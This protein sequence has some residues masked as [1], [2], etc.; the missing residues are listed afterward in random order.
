MKRYIPILSLLVIVLTLGVGCSTPNRER[1]S[2]NDGWL[3]MLGENAEAAE[4][5]Y[6]DS[7]WRQLNLPHDWS[8]ELPFAEDAPAGPGGGA[9]PGGL[10]WYRKHFTVGEEIK[11]KQVYIDFDG[12]YMNSEVFINGHSLGV[13]PFGYI[14]FRYDLTPYLKPGEDNVIAV[15]VD[16]SKQQ[17]G[18]AACRERVWQYV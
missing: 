7:D 17:I 16:N 5:L 14:T 13:R 15:K 11:D 2:F 18:R 6:D 4:P 8:I 3:F 12:V 10:G 9:L 1:T